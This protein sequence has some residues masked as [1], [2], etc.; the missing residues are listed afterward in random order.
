MAMN[1]LLPYTCDDS[2]SFTFP[3]HHASF[4]RKKNV[5]Q[6]LFLAHE[7][8]SFKVTILNLNFPGEPY[9]LSVRKS[10]LIIKLKTK[11]SVLPFPCVLFYQSSVCQNVL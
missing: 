11:V 6:G 4:P 10:D 2:Y 1:K 3:E 5:L 7:I 9:V 8:I